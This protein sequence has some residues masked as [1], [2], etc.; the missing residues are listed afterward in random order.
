MK[1]L[2]A[3]AAIALLS[4]SFTPVSAQE[5]ERAIKQSRLLFAIGYYDVFDDQDGVDFRAEYRPN[6]VVFIDNLKPFA[7]IELTSE[8][9]V[10][11]GGGLLYDWNFKPNWYFTPSFGVGLY[12][13][14]GDDEDLDHPIQ[15]RSQLEVSYEFKNKNRLGLSL[16]HLSNAGLGDDNPGTEVLSLSWSLPF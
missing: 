15:F 12:N 1:K 9:S 7:G 14:A 6:S 16:S 5:T 11:A 13:H 4:A 8:G 10:W 3:F 2:L